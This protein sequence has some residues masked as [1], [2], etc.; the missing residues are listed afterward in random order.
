MAAGGS[1]ALPTACEGRGGA[2]GRGGGVLG[3][4]TRLR[5]E[6]AAARSHVCAFTVWDCHH[7][8]GLA[9]V[10]QSSGEALWWA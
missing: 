4:R 8:W 2:R 9:M 7:V 1:F 6:L 5:G 3:S 10:C